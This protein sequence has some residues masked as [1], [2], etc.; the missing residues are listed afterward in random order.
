[1]LEWSHFVQKRSS[2]HLR[3]LI[4]VV[5]S[6]IPVDTTNKRRKMLNAQRQL[7]HSASHTLSLVTIGLSFVLGQVVDNPCD[8]PLST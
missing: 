3:W 7:Y 8:L 1:M 6:H 5:L 2:C 4:N